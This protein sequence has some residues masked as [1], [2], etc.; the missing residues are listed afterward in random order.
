[1][2]YKAIAEMNDGIVLGHYEKLDRICETYQTEGQLEKK[3]ISDLI[4]QGYERLYAKTIEDLYSN[5][6]IQIERLNKIEFNSNEWNR[7]L[8]E[9]LDCPNDTFV[10]KTS[11]IQGDGLYQFKF[12]NGVNQNIKIIDKKDIYNNHVQV[13][14]QIENHGKYDN[15]YDVTILVN[16]LPLVHIEL[17]KRGVNLCEAFN[18]IHRYTKESFNTEHSLYKY[19]Q[20]FVIS[21]GTYTRY[22][23]NTNSKEKNDYAFTCEWADARNDVIQD[24]EDFTQTFLAKRTVLEILI[25]YCVFN[26]DNTLLIMRPYQIAATERILWKI[27]SSFN[28]KVYGTEKAGGF[29]WHTTGTGKTLTSFKTSILATKLPYIDKVFF[30][31]DRKDLDYQAI[32]EYEKFQKGC[33]SGTNDTRE[34]KEAIERNDNKIIVTTIQKLNNF[35]KGNK[36][37]PVYDKQCILI[38]DECHRSQFGEAQK[39]ITKNFK[40]YYQF[41]FTGTPIFKDN[42]IGS[43]LTSSVFGAM[44]HSYVITN[45]IKDDKVLKFKID[46]IASGLEY[47][48][49]EKNVDIDENKLLL[50]PDRISKITEYIL[51]VFKFKTHRNTYLT[52]EKQRKEGFNAMFA[53]SSVKAAKAY[54]QEFKKQQSELRIA[55]IFSFAPNEEQKAKGEINDENFEP[56]MLDLSSKEFLEVAINDYNKMF[57]S[58]YSLDGKSFQEY[59]KDLSIKVKNREVDLLIVVGMFL[60]GFDAPALN[61]LFVDK[62]LQYHGLIQAFSRTNR[63]FNEV[64]TNGNIVCFRDLEKATKD[65][66]K[67]FGDENSLN[68]ILERS[69]KDYTEGYITNKG[70]HKKGFIEVCNELV[71]KFPNPQNLQFATEKKEFV[72]L[73]GEYLKLENILKNYDEFYDSNR[74]IPDRLVQ[75]MKGVYQD[76][77]EK[78]RDGK[79]EETIDFSDIEFH[80]DLLKTQE[81]NLDYIL[82]LIFEK[83]KENDDIEM[84]KDEIR[85]IIKSSSGVRAKE[86]LIINFITT[87]DLDEIKSPE[88]VLEKFYNYAKIEKEKDIL[89]LQKEENLKE[90]SKRVIEQYIKKGNEDVGGIDIDQ[91]LPPM[92]RRNSKRAEKKE[93]VIVKIKGLVQKFIGI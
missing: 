16:G 4:A 79:F 83:Y 8:L 29:I 56:D 60:T 17:K 84:L 53:V 13:V 44:L 43:T 87:T 3:L 50:H 32:K 93:N 27:E 22:F 51:K 30:V 49:S 73:F 67:L 52:I 76:I 23:A 37:H 77:K 41:G 34:L 12:D 18:Q 38:F 90:D 2:S 86:E 55:T 24:L 21:N 70:I 72:K 92:T 5:L 88:D 80:M 66:I 65:A 11:K 33:V 15:R 6:K 61:T 62:N 74:I 35:I 40:K 9:Y 26:S 36:K 78:P 57:G 59:Y 58:S 31:V 42:A 10:E 68:I 63:K 71:D 7:F 89:K 48:E 81:I 54:Y 46:Y 20:I 82:T 19:I 85:R 14:N 75:D 28:S 1:M 25:K 47:E 39:N 91:I 45:A 69:Y 64:K